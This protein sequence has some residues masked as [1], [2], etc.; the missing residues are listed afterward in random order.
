MGKYMGSPWGFIRGKV[1]DQVGGAWKGIDWLRKRIMPTQRGTM[2]LYDQAQA[3]TGVS[4]FS[5]KQFN[6]R[7]IAFGPLGFMARENLTNWINPVWT[8]LAKKRKLAIT[9][10]N[11]FLKTSLP[12]WF[13]SMTNTALK[14]DSSTNTPDF[15]HL[16]VSDGDLEGIASITTAV[17][18]TADGTIKCT[19]PIT[20]TKNGA[21]GDKVYGVAVAKPLVDIRY[22]PTLAFY[23]DATVTPSVTRADGGI[24]QTVITI[25][26]G[27]TATNV[28]VYLFCRDAAN[29]IG[30]SPSIGKVCVAP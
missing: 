30:F 7:K 29:S 12:A 11:L 1:G 10:V 17:Y 25:P 9:G 22:K 3:G 15:T 13:A 20:H 6:V 27:L 4:L 2:R 14:Y 19:Y 8:L 23:G 24:A 16:Q 18:D 21:A 28:I 26:L 5:Y